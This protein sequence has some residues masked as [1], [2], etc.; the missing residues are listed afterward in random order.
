[1]SNMHL[2]SFYFYSVPTASSRPFVVWS[3]DIY[4]CY[5]FLVFFYSFVILF[6]CN[7]DLFRSAVMRP[8][9]HESLL[10]SCFCAVLST[11]QICMSDAQCPQGTKCLATMFGYSMC[12]KIGGGVQVCSCGKISLGTPSSFEILKRKFIK[13]D[14]KSCFYS[15]SRHSWLA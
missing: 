10:I 5:H 9:L 7:V 11:T 8:L 13:C 14:N 6:V 2:A 3:S 1:M 4:W 12:S 15:V